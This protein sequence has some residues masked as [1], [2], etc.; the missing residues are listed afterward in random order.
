MSAGRSGTGEGPAPRPADA[1][2][3]WP[4][5]EPTRSLLTL[6]QLEVG[7]LERRAVD[8]D[9]V[10]RVAVLARPF[11]ERAEDLHWLVAL[12]HEPSG[13]RA[14]DRRHDGR[15]ERAGVDAG[16]QGEG[17][18]AAGGVATAERL[19]GPLGDDLARGDDAD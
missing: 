6:R 19:R 8:V 5:R 10:E 18:L 1:S 14:G 17:D 16:R 13:L 4:S 3:G 15:R 7:V 9:V 11:R 2:R 12:E